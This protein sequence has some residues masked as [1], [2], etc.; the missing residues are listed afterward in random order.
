MLT[1]YR[2]YILLAVALLHRVLVAAGVDVAEE[3]LSQALDVLLL[4]GAGLAARAKQK[5]L[6]AC[7]KPLGGA[8]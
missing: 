4:I 5:R 2:T 7:Q 6:D 8:A 1:G 3:Q